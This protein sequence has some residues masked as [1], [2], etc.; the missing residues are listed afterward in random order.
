MRIEAELDEIH[1][2]RLLRLQQQAGRPLPEF[3]AEIL[4]EAIDAADSGDARDESPW[5]RAFVEA[6][7]LGCVET[8]QQL[9]TTYKEKL[10]FS[11]KVGGEP[12]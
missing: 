9:S 1:A 12:C 11:T 10:D 4:R 8:D 7:L 2:E 6:G 5:Y 3:V